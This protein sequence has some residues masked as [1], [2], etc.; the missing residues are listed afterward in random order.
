[1]IGLRDR[2]IRVSRSTGRFSTWAGHHI[3]T[4]L[5]PLYR[6]PNGSQRR[7]RRVRKI[8]PPNGI[9]SPDR[10]AHSESLTYCAIPARRTRPFV[11][12]CAFMTYIWQICVK[13]HIGMHLLYTQ[14]HGRYYKLDERVYNTTGTRLPC[15]ESNLHL[16]RE[17]RL[18][19]SVLN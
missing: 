11:K 13:N 12:F 18:S 9:R 1:M 6:R 2:G 15:T 19:F 3:S 10:P 14:E 5:Y 4:A 8:S 16:W 7:T 17:K